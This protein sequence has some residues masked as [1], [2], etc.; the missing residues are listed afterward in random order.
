MLSRSP[1]QT[2]LDEHTLAQQADIEHF[3]QSVTHHLPASEGYL[4]FY[5]QGQ[6]HNPTV[7]KVIA[8]CQSGWPHIGSRSQRTWDH[9]G[10]YEK[11]LPDWPYLTDFRQVDSAHESKQ[12]ADFNWRHRT[13][14][15][16]EL[17][18]STS[19]RL[20]IGKQ[21]EPGKLI[22]KANA[23]RFYIVETATG[24]KCGNWHYLAPGPQNCR[25]TNNEHF[26]F[27]ASVSHTFFPR[28]P[29]CCWASLW[30]IKVTN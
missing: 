5:C 11:N 13:R 22:T 29:S 7:S 20:R 8:Y 21:L 30:N 15:L 4:N 17:T 16:P 28:K 1:L 26:K 3:I 23:P 10:L 9:I 24:R 27:D 2:P 14:P 19:V 18:P 25:N 12:Q 6:T